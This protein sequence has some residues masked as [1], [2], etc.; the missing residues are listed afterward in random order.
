MS[1]LTVES[2]SKTRLKI[3]GVSL[4]EDSSGFAFFNQNLDSFGY[5]CLKTGRILWSAKVPKGYEAERIEFLSSWIFVQLSRKRG[6]DTVWFQ[7]DASDGENGRMIER[8]FSDVIH[9]RQNGLCAPSGEGGVFFDRSIGDFRAI[10]EM[11]DF[12]NPL[13]ATRDKVLLQGKDWPEGQYGVYQR[14]P[15]NLLPVLSEDGNI[16]V[17][18]GQRIATVKTLNSEMF[19]AQ[20]SLDGGG[21]FTVF[22]WEGKK[23][24]EIDFCGDFKYRGSEVKFA[25]VG[26]DDKPCL[27]FMISG[28]DYKQEVIGYDLQAREVIWRRLLPGSSIGFHFEISVNIL[29]YGVRGGLVREWSKEEGWGNDGVVAMDTETGELIPLKTG[30]MGLWMCQGLDGIVFSAENMQDIFLVKSS[31]ETGD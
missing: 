17:N 23:I 24:A 25:L 4:N 26:E 31:K 6:R 12:R 20:A 10:K 5:F 1:S 15:D 29:L 30:K 9:F 21:E 22:S 7:V 2:L 28:K 11:A 14:D 13:A 3:C 16:K 27:F 19:V 18:F 8:E